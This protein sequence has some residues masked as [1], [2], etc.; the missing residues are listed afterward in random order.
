MRKVPNKNIFKKF[1]NFQ[2]SVISEEVNE[3]EC[4]QQPRTKSAQKVEI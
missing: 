2:E 4:G 3:S 1:T